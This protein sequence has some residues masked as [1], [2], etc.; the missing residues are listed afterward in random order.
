MTS[1]PA[2]NAKPIRMPRW[3]WGLCKTKQCNTVGDLG[4]G[5]CQ[6]HWDIHTKRQDD[7]ERKL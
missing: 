3:T 5:F 2:H 6:V 1:K 7:E 4:N